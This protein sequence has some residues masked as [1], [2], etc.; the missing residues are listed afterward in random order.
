LLP[1]LFASLLFA[2]LNG[3]TDSANI[4]APVISCQALSPRRARLMATIAITLAPFVFGTAVA[5]TIG[6]RIITPASATLP[7]VTA[8][9]I[10]AVGWSLITWRVGIPSSSSHALVGGLIGAV[11]ASG[12]GWE[13]LQWQGI[14][15]VLIALFFS[16]VIGLFI[17]YFI[18]RLVY[19]AGQW[20]TPRINS[21]FR[22]G[23]ILTALALA[24]S[25]G[26]NDAQKSIG[27]LALGVAAANATPFEIP[28]WVIGA[29]MGCVGLGTL[30]GSRRM[31]R[32]LGGKFYR[33]RPIH[34][35]A[36]QAAAAAVIFSAAA[37]GGPVSTTHVVSTSILGAGA[38]ERVNKV[39]WGVMGDILWAWV[40]TIPATTAVG[41]GVYWG[42][43]QVR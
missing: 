10:S 26:A 1:L 37:L 22:F 30:I 13:A 16:P 32:A 21:A 41:I 42:L 15:R 12:G 39:R 19:F 34:G 6:S 29:A 24:L 28:L 27:L 4:I 35:F 14:W 18:T 43:Q 3:L 40:L 9:A 8:A 11:L 20:A 38:A 31:V 2:F 23:Q 17:G 33:L 7:V 5:R 36:A 25:Y